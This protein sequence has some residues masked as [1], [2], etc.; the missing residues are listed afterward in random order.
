ME[1]EVCIMKC[2]YC[3]RSMEQGL[4][5]SPEPINFLKEV[6]FINQPKVKD[7]EFN[8]A[9]SSMGKRATVDAWLCRECRKIVISY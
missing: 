7:G 8:L 5:A 9:K 1:K 6:H 2:P 4:I 3:S